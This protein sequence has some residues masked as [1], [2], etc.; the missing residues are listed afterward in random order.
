M[1]WPSLKPSRLPWREP[2]QH[3]I[4]ANLLELDGSFAKRVLEGA[5]LT[6]Q[7][8]DRWATASAA[9]ATLWETFLAYSAVVDR[10]APGRV[11]AVRAERWEDG[12]GASLLAA[13][14]VVAEEPLFID[15]AIHKRSMDGE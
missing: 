11:R 2:I 13:E 10:I 9:L 8:R 12:N 1:P 15:A 5:T 14:P 4:Q 7:T 3:A 6:G